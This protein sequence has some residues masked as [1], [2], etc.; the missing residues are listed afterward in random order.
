MSY[1][2]QWKPE[3]ILEGWIYTTVKLEKI[4]NDTKKANRTNKDYIDNGDYIDGDCIDSGD[5]IDSGKDT[6]LNDTMHSYEVTNVQHW[7]VRDGW[8]G[9]G[10]KMGWTFVLRRQTTTD[11]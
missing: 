7:S 6:V 9:S 11:N 3:M 1:I 2:E 5:N 10:W 8:Y 4:K